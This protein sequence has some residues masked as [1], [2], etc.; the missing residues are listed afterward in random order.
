MTGAAREPRWF[1]D[2]ALHFG[3][4]VEDTFVPQ[5]REGERP[6]DEYELTDHYRRFHEDLG[7]AV[8]AG[9]TFL[10]W[11]VPWYRVHPAPGEWEWSWVDRVVDRFAEL[12]LRPVIDLLH[13]GT[14]L[15]LEG[16]FAHP[17]YPKV[18]AEYAVAFAERYG[19]RVTDYT[20]VNE[21]MIH[22]LF[23][24]AYG[25]WPPYL[26]GDQGLVAMV[27][28]LGEGFVRTQQG[29]SGT[30]GDRATFM[31]VD[32]AMRYTG[33]VTGEHRA[34]V[35]RLRHQAHLV[36]D[37]VTG[38]VDDAH[39]L[40]PLLRA[41]G[42]DDTTLAWFSEQAVQPDVM[43]VNYYPRISTEVFEEGVH[44]LG[45][46]SD[47]RPPHDAGVAGLVE[48]LAEAERRHGVPVMLTE[49]SVTAPEADR[50]AWLHESV[51]A[52]R[53]LR[54]L[55]HRVVG[56]T[57]W[58]VFDMYEWTY[59]HG[60]GPREDYLLTMGLW[61]LVEDGAG[62]LDRRRTPVADTYRAL[63]TDREANAGT[64]R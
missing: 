45:G 38:K 18:V 10:R 61:D 50:I 54:A 37:L 56:Y 7:L 15:W 40:A 34:Q 3:L 43:G 2:G 39:P 20:P 8:D 25:Y 63:A 46:F 22:A 29:I 42:V 12:G 64:L 23:S 44:H 4:G 48:V 55:G 49:T 58:P 57:W 11:G 24:G 27:R 17:D 13:Y 14:P 32:A 26:S 52:I 31:H 21:P 9:A 16:Q 36:E 41:G 5:T 19:D 53:T 59:R 47:P 60:E 30:L 51:A 33:D 6:I 1:E 35:E 62:G 28:A